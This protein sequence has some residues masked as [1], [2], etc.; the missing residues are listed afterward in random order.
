MNMV[1]AVLAALLLAASAMVFA[2][3]G[4]P[5]IPGEV[6]VKLR[7][8]GALDALLAKYPLAV[9]DRFGQ[10]PIY[11]LKVVGTATVSDVVAALGAEEP[12]TADAAE[13]KSSYAP[14]QF[15]CI[16]AARPCSVAQA[17]HGF[18]G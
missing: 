5:T 2:G 10:R 4:D 9:I 16:K 3:D 14:L 12:G 17:L 1:R 8:S 6:L 7:A 15:V 11:R 18:P 13:A